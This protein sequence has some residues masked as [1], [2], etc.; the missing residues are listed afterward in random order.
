MTPSRSGFLLLGPTMS[1]MAS[2]PEAIQIL[3]YPSKPDRIKQLDTFLSDRVKAVLLDHQ[4]DDNQVFVRECRSGRRRYVCR[5]FRVGCD[6]RYTIQ[7]ATAIILERNATGT[8]VMGEAAKQ[9]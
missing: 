2:N 3:S 5:S 9:F 1:P 8:V 6:P 4:S 7:P